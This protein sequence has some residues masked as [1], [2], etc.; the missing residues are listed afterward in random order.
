MDKLILVSVMAFSLMLAGPSEFASRQE[1]GEPDLS[2]LTVVDSYFALPQYK[3]VVK[4][5]ASTGTKIVRQLDELGIVAKPL[6][7]KQKT[8]GYGFV[9]PSLVV[10]RNL[11]GTIEAP[12]SRTMFTVQHPAGIELRF[13]ELKSF[14]GMTIVGPTTNTDIGLNMKFLDD[15]GVLIKLVN[16][17]TLHQDKSELGFDSRGA[18]F[19]GLVM[20]ES[21]IRSVQIVPTK[22][23]ENCTIVLASIDF[24]C[25]SN[26]DS[27]IKNADSYSKALDEIRDWVDQ[28][29]SES[30]DIRE[31]ASRN[32]SKLEPEYV[33]FFES[34][35]PGPSVESKVR[36]AMIIRD[37]RGK[38]LNL[39]P[40]GNKE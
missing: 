14:V 6:T 24:L 37:L 12:F 8:H 30:Y 18:V 19:R 21:R 10:N 7:G 15:Q 2:Q 16:A 4:E 17:D 39:T 5:F 29:D 25:F 32:L 3:T 22:I 28:F 9:G 11:H 40:N 36:L 38:G 23:P 20:Q 31:L 27:A 26:S 33:A 35:P 1:A 34:I 13:E